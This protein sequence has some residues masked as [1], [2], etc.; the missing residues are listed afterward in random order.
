MGKNRIFAKNHFPKPKIYFTKVD[1]SKN[2]RYFC[3]Y[4]KRRLTA[5]ITN[6]IFPKEKIGGD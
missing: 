4:K 6:A 5:K 2:N 1:Y 3:A